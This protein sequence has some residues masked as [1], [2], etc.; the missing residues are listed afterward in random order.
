MES[1][2]LSKLLVKARAKPQRIVFPESGEEKILLAAREVADMGAVLPVF[3]GN[4]E[5]VAELAQKLNISTDGFTIVDHTDEELSA[6][7]AIEFLQKTDSLSEKTLKRK[8]RNPLHFAAAMVRV[9]R[10]DCVAAGFSCTT[11]DAILAY[12]EMVGM[13]EGISSVSSLCVL[14]APGFKGPEGSLMCFTDCV[15]FP[16]PNS[17]ELADIAISA[18]DTMKHM[19]GWEPRVAMLSFSTK[20]GG[21]NEIVEKVVKAV[22]IANMRR[23]DILIDGEFQLDAAILPE[24]AAKK[25]KT[26]SKVA[27]RANIIVFPDLNAGNIGVKLVNIF[28]GYPVHGAL[29]Q[30]LASPMVDFSRSAP[31]DQMVG[32]L[33]MLS[34]VAQEK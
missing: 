13:K 8:L 25:V 16:N 28:A 5:N 2:F 24:V 12:Q 32:A 1:E 18:A 11:A 17:N 34:A 3:I 7:V 4:T 21:E 30:G 14:E 6:A 20:G 22:E 33:I 19:L 26:E 31:L 10:A 29:L 23:P 9:G 15:V 27:G